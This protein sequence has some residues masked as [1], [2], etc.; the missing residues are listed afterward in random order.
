MTEQKYQELMNKKAQ[1]ENITPAEVRELK[2]EQV[3][4][5]YAWIIA[6]M[7]KLH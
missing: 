4:Q 1:G 7:S 6:S 3:R 5:N 2:P